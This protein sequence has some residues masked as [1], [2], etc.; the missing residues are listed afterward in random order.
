MTSGTRVAKSAAFALAVLDILDE[1]EPA[2]ALDVVSVIEATLE[3]PRQVLMAQ[4][5]AARGEAVAQMKADGLEYEER[6]ELLDDVTW[7]KPLADMLIDAFAIY[8]QSHPWVYEMGLSPKSVV[9]EMYENA[10]TF[11]E[12]VGRY[13]LG[14]AEG[15]LLRYLSDAYRALR[16]T[17]PLGYRDDELDDLHGGRL[18]VRP[19]AVGGCGTRLGIFTPNAAGS[20]RSKR[21]RLR[22]WGNSV[23]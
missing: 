21:R 17:V 10:M 11:G 20:S 19:H 6:L 18:K 23:L 12:Y 22:A 13:Q 14:R 7:P 2:Y 15:I 4:Q 9:R 1:S 16:Q 5:F 3:D 8:R